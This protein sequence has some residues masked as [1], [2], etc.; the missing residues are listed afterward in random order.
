M[1]ELS[2]PGEREGE[3]EEGMEGGR[4]KLFHIDSRTATHTMGMSKNTLFID[5]H[6]DTATRIS[7]I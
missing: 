7:S 6:T 4:F 3:R 1:D 2:Q 5:Q